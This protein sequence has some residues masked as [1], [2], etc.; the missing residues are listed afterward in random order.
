M[1]ERNEN[2]RVVGLQNRYEDDKEKLRARVRTLFNNDNS[3]TVGAI[4][5]LTG[6]TPSWIWQVL[7]KDKTD[8][9]IDMVNQLQENGNNARKARLIAMPM[10]SRGAKRTKV[11]MPDGTELSLFDSL[12]DACRYLEKEYNCRFPVKSV[13]ECIRRGKAYKGFVFSYNCED[14]L[15]E[16]E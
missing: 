9:D 5:E 4:S 10:K 15:Q 6:I 8:I 13:G 14:C 7:K 12:S 11:I 2:A 3:I 16:D 1:R